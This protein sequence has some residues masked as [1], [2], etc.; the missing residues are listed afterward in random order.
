MNNLSNCHPFVSAFYFLSVLLVTMFTTNPLLLIFAL[1]GSIAFLISLVGS[2]ELLKSSAFYIPLFLLIAITNPLFSH[3][4]VTELFFVNQNAVTLEAVLYGVDIAV[5]LISVLFWFRCFN[6]VMT[7][8]KLLY[9]T[10]KIS[11]KISLVFSSALRFIPLFKKQAKKIRQ[12]QKTMGLFST[13]SFFEKVK[14]EL[15]VFLSL[16]TW[17]LENAIDTGA[18]MKSRGYGLKGRTHFSLYHFNITDI[19]MSAIII[20]CD[21]VVLTAFLN[22]KLNFE[23]YP[24]I[25]TINSDFLTVFSIIVFGVLCFLPF[26]LEV[27]EA[28]KWKYFK[29][30]I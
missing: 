9:L 25:S 22:N 7:N 21:A 8:D 2:R 1:L 16:V 27:K 23:F 26:I 5:M 24:E 17:S 4:G 14:S 28:F 18:S 12:V 3:N 10:G 6:D 20:L 19:Y 11:P 30:K 29:S 15:I 13:D